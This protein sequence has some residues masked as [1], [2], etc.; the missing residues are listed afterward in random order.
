MPGQTIRYLHL[1]DFHVGKDDYAQLHLFEKIL[2]HVRDRK[3]S[4]A[5]I[6]DL[7]FITGDI[8]NRGQASEYKTFRSEFLTKL[9][10]VL[11]QDLSA[12][13]F[14][15]PG[16]H[17]VDR[18]YVEFLAREAMIKPDAK[19]FDANE[20]GRTKRQRF[21]LDGVRAYMEN[22]RSRA[23]KHWLDSAAGAFS[24]ILDIRGIQLGIVGINTAWLS[25]DDRD[26]GQLTAGYHLVREA[27]AKVQECDICIV[28][29]HHPLNWL[30]AKDANQIRQ[31]FGQ[32]Q[33][34]Y[35][36]GHLHQARAQVQ[37]NTAGQNFLNV[38]AGAAFQAREDEIWQNGLLWGEIDRQNHQLKLQPYHWDN[39]RHLD[40]I[41]S[42][43]AFAP[44]RKLPHEDW[45]G[46]PLPGTRQVVAGQQSQQNVQTEAQSSAE[47]DLIEEPIQEL[48]LDIGCVQQINS[49]LRLA[50]EYYREGKKGSLSTQQIA[51]FNQFRQ[52]F[53]EQSQTIEVLNDQLRMLARKAQTLIQKT[54]TTLEAEIE[55]LRSTGKEQLEIIAASGPEALSPGDAELDEQI[56]FN[57]KR[58]EIFKRFK[59]RLAAGK[60]AARWL[61]ANR[62]SLAT[63]A[64][65]AAL[66]EH[67]ELE[68]SEVN[69]QL[70]YFQWEI[71]AHLEQLAYSLSWGTR[72]FLDEPKFEA[73]PQQVNASALQYIKNHR[74]PSHFSFEAT[75]Q[76]TDCIDYLIGRLLV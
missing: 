23:P 5:W 44:Q 50:E 34:L 36:H 37:E 72:V 53:K 63:R 3:K 60:E 74:I 59:D 69:Q 11:E 40:W 1:S 75:V 4:Q 46:F 35:L 33:V 76:L 67:P 73:F 26:E 61:E 2:D 27:L 57:E 62:K 54:Q 21:L 10:A 66:K 7:V 30:L 17:D 48:S 25:K 47:P 39:I 31:L 22:E 14:V 24:T 32:H 41:L 6:P 18:N 15:V 64:A 38:Q 71:Q 29:G 70:D 9:E 28:L 43:G 51:E 45:W 16:N 19:V 56:Q 42:S 13:L 55:E 8:A 58:L 12:V 68:A 52:Q 65:Q 49:S 20:S